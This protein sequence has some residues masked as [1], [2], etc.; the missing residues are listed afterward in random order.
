ML[1][2]L[3]TICVL[4]WSQFATAGIDD[5]VT[6][7]NKGDFTAAFEEFKVLAQQG[8][9]EAQYYLWQMYFKGR[10]TSQ[11]YAQGL[12]WIQMAAEHGLVKAQVSL[13]YLYLNGRGVPKDYSR[14]VEWLTKAAEQGDAVAEYDLAIQYENGQ[15]VPQDYKQ[16]VEWYGKAA[17]HGDADA[18]YKLGWLY[19]VNG[20]GVLNQDYAQALK[21][22]NLAAEQGQAAAQNDLGAMYAAGNG[23]TQ[24][25]VQAGKWTILSAAS[26][27]EVAKNKMRHIKDDIGMNA[28]VEAQHLAGEWI[29]LHAFNGSIQVHVPESDNWELFLYMPNVVFGRNGKSSNESYVAQVDMFSLPHFKNNEEFMTFVKSAIENDT[30]PERFNALESK[31]EFADQRGYPCVKFTGVAEDKERKVSFFSSKYL[32]LQFNSLYCRHPQLQNIGFSIAVSHRGEELDTDLNNLA[33]AFVN[34]V[35]VP[36]DVSNPTVKKMGANQ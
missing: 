16:A 30:P 27:F 21:W 22:Y 14:A 20:H 34:G 23:V 3:L 32:K 28:Y 10:G 33:Q 8:D 29:A 13:G 31:Y 25:Y 7:L 12:K 24:D 2:I 35:Q 18:Q 4:F 26:G 19:D 1:K 5:A 9:A 11:D 15:G 6:K 36:A 17:E